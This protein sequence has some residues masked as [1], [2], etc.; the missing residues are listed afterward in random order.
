MAERPRGGNTTGPLRRPKTAIRSPRL[1]TAGAISR[2]CIKLARSARWRGVGG[3]LRPFAQMGDDAAVTGGFGRLADVAAVQN[4]PVVRV[5]FVMVGH[6][7]IELHLHFERR[8]P[9]RKPGAVADAED[10]RID[11]DGRLAERLVE[12][13]VGAL[14]PDAGQRLERFA[15]ARHLAAMPLQ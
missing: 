13:Y 7:L 5:N 3:L 10:M 11:R 4:Q 15:L 8:E 1:P 9:G 14:A 2:F 6:H 12:H